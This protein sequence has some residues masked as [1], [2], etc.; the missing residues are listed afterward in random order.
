MPN[1][2][3]QRH[4]EP[5]GR[6]EFTWEDAKAGAIRDMEILTDDEVLNE[7][8]Q[9][10]IFQNSERV[11]IWGGIIE[12]SVAE[13]WDGTARALDAVTAKFPHFTFILPKVT[14]QEE[15][16]DFT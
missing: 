13:W 2:R 6:I 10:A 11:P 5:V 7:V 3:L 16:G 4:G 15:V 1:I 8:L 9:E 14:L 12:P